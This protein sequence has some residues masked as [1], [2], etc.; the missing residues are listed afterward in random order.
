MALTD[1][2]TITVDSTT[3]RNFTLT[4]I[5]GNRTLGFPSGTLVPGDEYNF[6][7]KQDATGSRTLAYGAGYMFDADSAFA[8]G[9]TASK[10]SFF[11]GIVLDATH[12]LL[13]LVAVNVGV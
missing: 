10:S 7:I 2:A 3:G 11:T 4:S 6:W 12:I 1:A 5:G 8:I 13:S 9:T